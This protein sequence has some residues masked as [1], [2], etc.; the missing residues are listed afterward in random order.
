MVI[1]IALTLDNDRNMP[2]PNTSVNIAAL[3]PRDGIRNRANPTTTSRFA[4]ALKNAQESL[5]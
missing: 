5:D 4:N 3:P 2:H 1:I